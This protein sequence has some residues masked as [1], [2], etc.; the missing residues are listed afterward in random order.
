MSGRGNKTRF[1]QTAQHLQC[2][3][4]VLPSGFRGFFGPQYV[5]HAAGLATL[6]PLCNEFDARN[7]QHSNTKS[8]TQLDTKNEKY[9]STSTTEVTNDDQL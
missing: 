9:W 3:L 4:A 1:L 7:K 6:L 2:V 5:Q 8:N